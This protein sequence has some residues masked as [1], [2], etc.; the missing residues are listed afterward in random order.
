MTI[1]LIK[2]T[3]NHYHKFL[4]QLWLPYVDMMKHGGVHKGGVFFLE[5]WLYFTVA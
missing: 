1:I 4:W 3:H 5:R 2:M